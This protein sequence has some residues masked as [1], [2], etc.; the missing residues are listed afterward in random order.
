MNVD[1]IIIGAGS[2]GSVLANRLSKNQEN[3]VLLIEAGGKPNF[4]S[5]ILSV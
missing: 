4:L 5:K 3:S 1:F 2:S